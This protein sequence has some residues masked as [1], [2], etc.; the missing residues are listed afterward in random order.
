M[1]NLNSTP[2]KSFYNTNLVDPKI[3]KKSKNKKT[4]M[5]MHHHSSKKGVFLMLIHNLENQVR[6]A[7][8]GSV[9]SFLR[10]NSKITASKLK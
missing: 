3:K 6:P 1:T 5:N 8:N 7:E 2:S 4:K 10:K 9:L